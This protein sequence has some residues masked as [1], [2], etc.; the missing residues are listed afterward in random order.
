MQPIGYI[1]G[2]ALLEAIEYCA[3]QI[4][5]S[6][7]EILLTKNR[8]IHDGINI[9]FG[10]HIAPEQHLMLPK[11][12]VIFNTEQLP[13]DSAW[14]N[15][16]YRKVLTDNFVWDYSQNNLATIPHED[17]GLVTFLHDESLKKIPIS[18]EKKWDLIFYGSINERRKKILDGLISS[19]LKI[20]V[21]FGIYGPERDLLIGQSRAVLNLHF[22]ESQLLQQIRVFYPLINNIPVISESFPL[23][24]APAI[25]QSCLFTPD[26]MEFQEYVSHLCGKDGDLEKKSV[27]KF[28][29]FRMTSPRLD[30]DKL[31]DKTI[32]HFSDMALIPNDDVVF[33]NKINL[34]SG[35]DYRYGY[36]NIDLRKEV[37]P[38]LILDLSQPI[39]FPIKSE[40]DLLGTIYLEENQIKEIVANDVLEHVPNLEMLMSNCLKILAIGG[41]FLINVPYDLSYGAWQDPTHIR[42]FNQNSWLYYTDWFWYLGWFTHRFDMVE[43]KFT[44]SSTGLELIKNK[45]PQDIILS[46]PR[47]IDSMQ[48]TLIKRETTAEEKTVARAYGNSLI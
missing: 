17:K 23:V 38:D 14:V 44:A 7:H 47:A 12:V 26:N 39:Q 46:T 37:S 13:V 9:I 29:E 45:S 40:S 35:K 32:I 11:N 41:K 16:S 10:A 22:Y 3:S 20:K 21:I 31:I 27:I 24:S 8:I 42:A 2:Q 28:D 43:C 18:F 48:V 1:H 25:Y 36:L 6:G 30:F 5:L 33:I 34:G 15:D 19:G 4:K